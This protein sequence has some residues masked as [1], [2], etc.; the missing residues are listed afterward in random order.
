M[1][2]FR[3]FKTAQRRPAEPMKRVVDPAAWVAEDLKDVS[4][5]SYRLTDSDAN[6]LAEAVATVRRNDVSIVDIQKQDFPLNALADVLVDVRRE[7]LDGRGIVMMS[8]FPLDRFDREG[9]AIAYVGLGA[10]LGASVLRRVVGHGG[11]LRLGEP[12][13]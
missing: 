7:L 11:L 3:S 10:H 2:E 5:W 12:P 4:R 8:N 13:M 6:E 9:N 1:G